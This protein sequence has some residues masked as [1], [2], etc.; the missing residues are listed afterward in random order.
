MTFWNDI[1]KWKNA[2]HCLKKKKSKEYLHCILMNWTI[3]LKHLIML[4]Y[5]TI[6][7]KNRFFPVNWFFCFQNFLNNS[8]E[9][10]FYIFLVV[11][12]E[13]FALKC[14]K[15]REMSKVVTHVKWNGCEE[16]SCLKKW[17]WLVPQK[18]KIF[19]NLKEGQT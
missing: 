3:S 12:W 4:T 17:G 18:I 19:I 7:L 15:H 13:V 11:W 10:Y 14:V 9:P 1:L 2:K 5:V 16:S 8:S 6:Q